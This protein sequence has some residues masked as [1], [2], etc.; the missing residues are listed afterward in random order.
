MLNHSSYGGRVMGTMLVVFVG[1]AAF[2]LIGDFCN[3][4]FNFMDS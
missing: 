2:V 4:L 3:F 1:L